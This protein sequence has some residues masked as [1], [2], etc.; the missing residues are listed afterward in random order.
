MKD[1][2]TKIAIIPLLLDILT[3]KDF[4]ILSPLECVR[5]FNSEARHTSQV[6]CDI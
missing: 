5:G 4:F 1:S 2:D 6:Q 3:A